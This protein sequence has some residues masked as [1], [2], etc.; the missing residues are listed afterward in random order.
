ME[1]RTY[2]ACQD[3][4]KAENLLKL[5]QTKGKLEAMHAKAYWGVEGYLPS[6]HRGV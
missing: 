1:N 5:R 3:R 4:D 6:R 2:I